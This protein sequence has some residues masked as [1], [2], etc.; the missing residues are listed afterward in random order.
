[1]ARQYDKEFKL[2]AIKYRKDHPELT[3]SAVC[4]NL[5]IS[6]PTYYKWANEFKTHEDLTIRG[7][8]NH[9][10]DEAKEIA[11]LKK[12]LQAKEDALRILKKAISIL[13][14]EPK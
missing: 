8:G 10:S 3:V 4:R 13:G 14:E 9:M 12:E 11:R 1:M 6:E 5:G 7:S 2:S